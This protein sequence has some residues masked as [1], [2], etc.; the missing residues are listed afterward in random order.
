[1][2]KSLS[3]LTS[4]LVLTLIV[5]SVVLVGGAS[6]ISRQPALADRRVSPPPSR[7]QTAPI[8]A[9]YAQALA[10][11]FGGEYEAAAGLF[12]GLSWRMPGQML[13]DLL[14][15]QAECAF[16]LGRSSQASQAFQAYLRSA[17]QG[18]RAEL[19]A[20]RVSRLN[21]TDQ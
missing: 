17:P 13:D 21:Q 20:E 8:E 2:T 19:A 9:V 6:E 7:A 15:W 3:S 5:F 10:A 1:M 4:L 18:Q 16:R 14:F 12:E 11:Y